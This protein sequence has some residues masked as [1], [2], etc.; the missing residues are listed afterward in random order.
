LKEE[1]EEEKGD[2]GRGDTMP[3]SFEPYHRE[4][5]LPYT[6]VVGKSKTIF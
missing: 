1:G 5:S 6:K 3:G 2:L 4:L